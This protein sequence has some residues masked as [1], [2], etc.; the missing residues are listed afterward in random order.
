M[1]S[2]SLRRVLRTHHGVEAGAYSYG[3]LL[4]PGNAD[5][6]T[7]I[8]RYVSVGPGVRRFGANHP[9]GSLSLHP[10]WFNPSLG[11]ADPEFSIE[12]NGCEIGDD[13]W[14]GADVIILPGCRRIGVGSVIG[15]G[16]VVTTDI[17]DFA[18]AFGNPARVHRLRF[19]SEVCDEIAALAPWNAEPLGY[20]A[21]VRE[22]NNRRSGG[23]SGGSGVSA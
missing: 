6:G 1:Y 5:A 11:I 21:L 13:S 2:P 12:R 10:F 16:S 15:A 9:V 3:S 14:I 17:P 8:G 19:P 20:Q 22:F 18:I 4:V 23:A 7:T